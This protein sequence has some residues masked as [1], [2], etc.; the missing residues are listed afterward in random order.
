MDRRKTDSPRLPR[1]LLS[2][3]YFL[4]SS[5]V[6][7]T[8]NF[9]FLGY[10]ARFLWKRDQEEREARIQTDR[11]I[12]KSLEKLA[13]KTT[14]AISE[15]SFRIFDTFTKALI[16]HNQ[17]ITTALATVQQNCAEAQKL[18][19]ESQAKT[20]SDVQTANQVLVQTLK[21]VIDWC[22]I[23]EHYVRE[24]RA[25]KL[26]APSSPVTDECG[27][28]HKRVSAYF[29]DGYGRPTCEAC[30]PEGFRDAVDRGIAKL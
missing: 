4:V 20:L 5:I 16:F 15:N 30:K 25:M 6:V 29:I 12:Q 28:C 9:S 14:A 1:I 10:A 8:G 3:S 23:T 17:T 11:E 24:F 21:P 18:N 27:H 2:I 7:V 13:E 19:Q 22:Y 26:R